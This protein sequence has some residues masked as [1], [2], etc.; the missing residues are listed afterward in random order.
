MRKHLTA[1][2]LSLIIALLLP[3][4][5][6]K[7]QAPCS[8][9][10]PYRNCPACGTAKSVRAQQDNVLK[11]RDESADEIKKLRVEHIRDPNFNNNFY[12]NMAVEITGYVVSVVRGGVKETCN[13][14]RDDL[15]DIQINIVA[16]WEETTNV[17]KYVVLEI[18]PRWQKKLGLDDSNYKLMLTKL[19]SELERKWVTFRGWMFYDSVHIDESE[20]TNPGNPLNWRATPWEVHPVTYYKVLS[21]P[22][23]D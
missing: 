23:S 3:A 7:N 21:G 11:N 22:P 16:G 12:P 4:S 17:R 8:K 19:K 20:S 15:L 13:C 2:S 10:T 14:G 18:S 5:G 1:Q 6:A 9:G